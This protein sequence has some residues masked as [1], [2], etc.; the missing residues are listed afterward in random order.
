MLLS[1]A[2]AELQPLL[3]HLRTTVRDK[4]CTVLIQA[5]RPVKYFP[6]L[7]FHLQ[8]RWAGTVEA[9]PINARIGIVPFFGGDYILASTPLYDI[10]AVIRN[11]QEARVRR[12]AGQKFQ[13][14]LTMQDWETRAEK[15]LR[16]L[17]TLVLP[18]SSFLAI[19]QVAQDGEIVSGHRSVLG[20]IAARGAPRPFVLVPAKRGLSKRAAS[21][22]S[23]LDLILVNIQG[24]RGRRAINSV[25]TVFERCLGIAPILVAAAGPSDVMPF[26]EQLTPA[27]ARFHFMGQL[28]NVKTVSLTAVGRDRPSADRE[29][30]FATAGLEQRGH[31][32]AELVRMATA[33]WWA[34]RQALYQPSIEPVE[35]RRFITAHDRAL[36][37]IPEDAA[38]LTG[39]RELLLREMT[40]GE[41]KT[42]RIRATIDATLTVP[43]DSG[44]LVLVRNED[45]ARQFKES[46][47]REINVSQDDIGQLGI[48]VT[49]R[50]GLWPERPVSAAVTAGYFGNRTVDTLLGCRAAHLRLVLDPIEARA[51]WYQTQRAAELLT[52]CNGMGHDGALQKIARELSCQ[53][54][55]FGDTVELSLAPSKLEKHS[56]T[57]EAVRNQGPSLHHALLVFT[58]GSVIEVGLHARF[59][60]VREAGR[61]L[62]TLEACALEPGDQV[63]VIREDSRALF[64][65]RLLD[66]L[67]Q[68]PLARQAEKRATWL[69]V[70]Q[71]VYAARHT[72]AQAIAREMEKQGHPVD[73]ATIRSWLRFD[74]AEAIVPDSPDRF[75]A[76]ASALGIGMP[77]NELMELYN[78]IRNWRVNHRKFGRELA[79]AVRSAYLGRLDAGTLRKIERDWGFN[80]RQLI[81]GARVAIVD[82]VVLPEGVE[83]ATQ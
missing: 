3:D 38:L 1:D 67:D 44:T 63:V 61:R 20:R 82:E 58:D 37:E 78:G 32:I 6:L 65:E 4:C 41:L 17:K 60:V 7:P 25:S 34:M 21:N 22:F 50:R 29:F 12:G 75:T 46:L 39:V 18:G 76:F 68:G 57:D 23:A 24:I 11:R 9:L 30:E 70:V 48:Q 54:A 27:R 13:G 47:A 55:P 69:A 31:A 42:E 81:E 71:S 40:N 59:E 56:D 15:R 51:A 80:A 52:S 62:K 28:P 26:L 53:V 5:W 2:D 33:A 73:V 72:N 16:K 77:P 35:V 43:G 74:Q 14:D 83:Y 49:G 64:S 19:D 8:L 79:R 45:E 66:A 36:A 10:S